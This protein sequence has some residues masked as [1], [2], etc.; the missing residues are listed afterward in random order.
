MKKTK[1]AM[2]VRHAKAKAHG[3]NKYEMREICGLWL[4]QCLAGSAVE[5]MKVASLA[6]WLSSYSNLN[7]LK[8][9]NAAAVYG[10]IC[11]WLV[12]TRLCISMKLFYQLL[13]AQPKGVKR[14]PT[15]KCGALGGVRRQRSYENGGAES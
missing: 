1:K 7:V 6:V 5:E 12:M 15:K 14:K 3:I 2:A 4:S 13:E 9:Y 8:K 10:I 11:L